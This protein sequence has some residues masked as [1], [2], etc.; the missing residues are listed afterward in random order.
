MSSS[1]D[2][3]TAVSIKQQ[4]PSKMHGPIGEPSTESTP[5]FALKELVASLYREQN[6]VQN[7]LSSLGFALRSFNNLNQFLELTPLMAAR[8]TD[9]DG[10]AL[11]LSKRQNHVS[12]EQIHCQDHQMAQDIRGVINGI[13][14]QTNNKQA[15]PGIIPM[16]R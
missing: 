8:V 13:I 11:M 9:A 7:L 15:T 4:P 3:M 6:K 12:L 16:F 2:I 5:V 10:S 14:D 1:P